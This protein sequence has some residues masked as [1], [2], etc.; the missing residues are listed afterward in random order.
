MI[1]HKK[2]IIYQQL[3]EDILLGKYPG[4]MKLPKELDFS[5]ELEVGKITLRAALK[6]LNEEGLIARIPSKG[7][8]VVDQS[9]E[10]AKGNRILVINNSNLEKESPNNY[11]LPGIENTVAKLGYETIL[12]DENFFYSVPSD[13]L[14]KSLKS[15][16]VIGIILMAA[17]FKGDEPL[18]KKL[19]ELQFPVV[20]PHA[21]STDS[22]I[23]GFASIRILQDKAWIDAIRHLHDQGHKRVATLVMRK[24]EFR[25]FTE[26][27]HTFLLKAH[28]MSTEKELLGYAPYIQEEI[29]KVV[30]KWLDLPNLP[31]AILCFSDFLAIDVYETLKEKN[32]KIPEEM[33]VMGYCGFPGG[34]F[35]SPSLSTMDF[36]YNILGKMSVELL[37]QADEWF[38]P[39][40]KKDAPALI[41][42]HKLVVRDSTAL[43]QPEPQYMQFINDDQL[44]P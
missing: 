12:C 37:L 16:N 44:V 41:K 24:D 11:I 10:M 4:G 30:H 32:I 33:A 43:K 17:N 28:D 40:T 20:L 38:N 21:S 27:E 3:K 19:W 42:S 36:E 25:G 29:A 39:E 18:V 23:T 6:R 1:K 8:F 14:I 2:D 35:L 26:A 15:N 31:T 22:Q 13:E 9:L 34:N 7:T 5:R